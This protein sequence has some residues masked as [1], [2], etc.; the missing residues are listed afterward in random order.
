M[1]KEI[2]RSRIVTLH[3]AHQSLSDGVRE[4]SSGLAFTDDEMPSAFPNLGREVEA[5]AFVPASRPDQ[6]VPSICIHSS[7][8][9]RFPKP[10]PRSYRIQTHWMY[11][12]T[13]ILLAP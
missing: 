7:C 2:N 6:N 8:S 5:D 10:T 1:M 13:S 12:S 11:R 4:Q 9:T 3:H